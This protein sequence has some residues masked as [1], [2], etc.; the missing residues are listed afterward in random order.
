MVS[1]VGF[2]AA[3]LVVSIKNLIISQ[4]LLCHF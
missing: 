4:K 1:K 3:V 2:G